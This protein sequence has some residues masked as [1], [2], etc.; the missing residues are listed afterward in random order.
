MRKPLDRAGLAIIVPTAGYRKT[1]RVQDSLWRE[2]VGLHD[3]L[4]IE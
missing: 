1:L 3:H 4:E 2:K